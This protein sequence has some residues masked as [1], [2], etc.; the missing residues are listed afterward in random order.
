MDNQ[1]VF[2]ILGG[3]LVA[4]A[5]IVS[6]AGLR[7]EKFP[8]RRAADRVDPG[9]RGARRGDDDVRLAQRRGRAGRPRRR[10]RRVGGRQRGV[11]QHDGGERGGRSQAPAEAAQGGDTAPAQTTAAIDRRRGI[12]QRR[13]TG[14]TRSPDA[15]STA[16]TGPDLDAALKGKDETFIE[17][18]IVDPNKFVEKGYPPNVMPET[19][20]D[21]LSPDELSALVSYLAQT[22][23]G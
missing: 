18:S 17:D 14:A 7:F 2:Y 10:A 11:R 13:C 22:T 6:F 16:T 5:L 20:G 8:A 1:T 15:G 12:R 21:Q 3:C 9:D 19:Y 4:V 23:S